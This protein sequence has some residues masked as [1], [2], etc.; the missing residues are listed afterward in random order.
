MAERT[1]SIEGCGR[2]HV[3]KDMCDPHY[4]LWRKNG[5]VPEALIRTMDPYQRFWEYVDKEEGGCWIWTGPKHRGW[6]RSTR[7][8]WKDILGSSVLVCL[9]RGT[10]C[11]WDDNRS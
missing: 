2:P 3:A 1:C 6:V 4:R 10:Y 7:S 8:A 5:V 9:E 11:A